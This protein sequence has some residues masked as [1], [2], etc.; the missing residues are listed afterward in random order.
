[1][2]TSKSIP[3]APQLSYYISSLSD[4]ELPHY[5][6]CTWLAKTMKG[7]MCHHRAFNNGKFVEV[8]K[9]SLT[10]ST[11]T[12]L[13]LDRVPESIS[14]PVISCLC[15]EQLPKEQIIRLKWLGKKT[16]ADG[17]STTSPS[18]STHSCKR[19]QDWD[20]QSGSGQAPNYSQLSATGIS[21]MHIHISPQFQISIL[22]SGLCQDTT[23]YDNW[24]SAWGSLLYVRWT[25]GHLL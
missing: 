22:S 12:S 18:A 17:Q 23:C 4:N 6:C 8:Q 5:Y 19:L 7:L 2:R 20:L 10:I 21:S 14:L 24:G 1:M 25:P 16:G 9:V 15:G 11:F 13:F 3:A